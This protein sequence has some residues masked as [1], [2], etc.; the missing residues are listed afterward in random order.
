[1]NCI[2]SFVFVNLSVACS[3]DWWSFGCLVYEAIVGDSPFFASTEGLT[4]QKILSREIYWPR[5]L[6]PDAR[7]LIDRLL[8]VDVSKRIGCTERGAAEIMDHPFFNGINWDDLIAKRTPTPI[9]P[10]KKELVP[11][12]VES[13]T[14][15]TSGSLEGEGE[16]SS[17]KQSQVQIERYRKKSIIVTMDPNTSAARSREQRLR[18]IMLRE[19]YTELSKLPERPPLL[20]TGFGMSFPVANVEAVSVSGEDPVSTIPVSSKVAL[21]QATTLGALGAP[22]RCVSWN[23]KGDKLSASGPFMTSI[24]QVADI[25]STDSVRVWQEWKDE[26]G[27]SASFLEFLGD[28]DLLAYDRQRQIG[29]Y[30][31][32]KKSTWNLIGHTLPVT[33]VA[34]GPNEMIASGGADKNVF[35]WNASKKKYVEKIRAHLGTVTGIC[36]STSENTIVSGSADSRMMFFDPT[37]ARALKTVDYHKSAVAALDWCPGKKIVASAG[38][39]RKLYILDTGSW[40]VVHVLAFPTPVERVSFDPTGKYLATVIKDGFRIWDVATM[41]LVGSLRVRQCSNCPVSW[42]SSGRFLAV[43]DENTYQPLV[44]DCKLNETLRVTGE[45]HHHPITTMQWSPSFQCLAVGSFDKTVSL[46]KAIDL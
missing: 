33:C 12:T 5:D 23:R 7:D 2:L 18:S 42:D 21:K 9:S 22:I 15:Q 31:Q 45:S 6:P 35:I 14:I 34:R 16:E 39:D 8:T 11:K 30:S 17:K 29:I 3:V 19:M 27:S 43:S 41:K 28:G 26:T 36:W 25:P 40:S 10:R 13:T 4:Y 46:W 20:Q 37:A 44:Y 38:L 1:V 24:S 32:S